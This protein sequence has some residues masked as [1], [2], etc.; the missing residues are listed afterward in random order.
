MPASFNSFMTCPCDFVLSI[1]S[2]H[3][4]L[5]CFHPFCLCTH[6]YVQGIDAKFLEQYDI[7]HYTWEVIICNRITDLVR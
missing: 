6:T 3:G 5:D 4:Q 2:A 1:W 7:S